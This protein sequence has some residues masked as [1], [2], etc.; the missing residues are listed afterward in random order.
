MT[1]RVCFGAPRLASGVALYWYEQRR[2][3]APAWMPARLSAWWTRWRRISPRR[4]IVLDNPALGKHSIALP[5]EAAL[6]TM[7]DY[8]ERVEQE[9][10]G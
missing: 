8:L 6:H 3:Q 9:A 4:R 2:T 10:L 7:Q 1:Y 5:D